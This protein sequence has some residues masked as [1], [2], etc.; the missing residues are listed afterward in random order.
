M[1]CLAADGAREF[2]F[3]SLQA[4]KFESARGLFYTMTH[5][6]VIQEWFTRL[7]DNDRGASK[8]RP[9]Y[10]NLI[11]KDEEYDKYLNRKV[12]EAKF[13]ATERGAAYILIRASKN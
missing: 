9:W 4:E 8:P 2:I 11:V 13:V 12:N 6:R 10:I 5:A 3:K 1:V 7:H